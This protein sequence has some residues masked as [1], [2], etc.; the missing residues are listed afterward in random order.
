MTTRT[1]NTR[2][3]ESTYVRQTILLCIIS[4]ET[5]IN[6]KK[7][8][9]RMQI[10]KRKTVNNS[11]CMLRTRVTRYV[12]NVEPDT[13]A[14][15]LCFL[16]LKAC[17]QVLKPPAE[18]IPGSHCQNA[19]ILRHST[20]KRFTCT[21]FFC[22]PPT[23]NFPCGFRTRESHWVED[24]IHSQAGVLGVLLN[25]ILRTTVLLLLLYFLKSE[26]LSYL[27]RN[28]QAKKTENKKSLPL[29]IKKL[30]TP[31]MTK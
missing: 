18:P 17:Q 2:I 21:C 5:T 30:T 27:D 29:G 7:L 16:P 8:C 11:A 28:K 23:K 20:Q 1:Y 10:R 3:A 14:S 9:T 19:K 26:E 24:T 6:S 4:L 25:T 22:P 31:P 15:L 12:I 13:P